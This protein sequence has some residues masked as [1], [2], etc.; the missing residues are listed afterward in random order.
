MNNVGLSS[1][2]NVTDYSSYY[3][4]SQTTSCFASS[5][6]THPSRLE[7]GLELMLFQLL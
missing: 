3:H 6:S 1:N 4:E 2:A 5:M 7:R